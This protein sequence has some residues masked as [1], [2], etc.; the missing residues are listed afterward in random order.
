MPS[1]ENRALASYTGRLAGDC[2]TAVKVR[3]KE[4]LL[5]HFS[6]YLA[7]MALAPLSGS[8]GMDSLFT[9]A[10]GLVGLSL[11]LLGLSQQLVKLAKLM[12]N[13]GLD[14]KL[15]SGVTIAYA[16]AMSPIMILGVG[17]AAA[18]LHGMLAS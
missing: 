13:H 7:T 10:V 11:L 14:L 2:T 1:M 8:G 9:L 16:I 4:A 12:G 18:I 17:L 3:R 15:S 6:F 5:R